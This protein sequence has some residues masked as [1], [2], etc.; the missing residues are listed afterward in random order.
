MSLGYVVIEIICLL[1]VAF[2]LYAYLLRLE[3]QIIARLGLGGERWRALWP[4]A[5]AAR[6]LAKAGL[7]PAGWRRLVWG[8][9]A[10]LALVSALAMLAL[11]P[12][13][14]LSWGG[15]QRE[16]TLLRFEQSLVVFFILDGLSLAG[17]LIGARAW[18]LADVL[19]RARSAAW[20]G[21]Q[22]GLVGLLAVAGAATLAGSLDI[23]RIAAEQMTLP[24]LLYQPLA[25]LLLA[26]ALLGGGRRLPLDLP[27]AGDPTLADFHLQ[28]AGGPLALYHLAEYMRLLAGGALWA[29][30]YLAGPR[31]PWLAGPHWLVFKVAVVT[32]GLL[33]LR[34][35]WVWPQRARL[36]GN[37][38]AALLGLAAL[39]LALT[40]ALAI[41]RPWG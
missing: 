34:R 32:V 13:G 35:R 36:A 31:G 6:A 29:A 33:W 41:W 24:Y 39:N 12:L 9:G 37:G 14:A 18:G 7:W 26:V 15:A 2:L 17:M 3:R 10:L 40:W 4:L 8:C 19:A 22:Y 11:A 30:L 27:G 28:H 1:G 21:L 23:E 5:D 38:W 25:A 20:A 16:L